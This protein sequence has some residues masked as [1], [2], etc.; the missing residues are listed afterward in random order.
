MYA[1]Q[2]KVP[3]HTCCESCFNIKTILEK[4][5]K[6]M[7]SFIMVR[8]IMHK[9]PSKLFLHSLFTVGRKQFSTSLIYKQFDFFL[10]V[11]IMQQCS[12]V[13]HSIYIGIVSYKHFLPYLILTFYIQTIQEGIK[14]TKAK[15][16]LRAY[17]PII[18]IY[19]DD[20]T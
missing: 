4:R 17:C 1:I 15:E 12:S 7:F 9:V 3:G 2:Y 10:T 13:Y 18:Y 5:E 8:C 16:Q 14:C 20:C 6:N 11:N 19:C